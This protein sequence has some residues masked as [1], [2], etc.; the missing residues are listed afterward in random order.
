MPVVGLW[1]IW[2][3]RK[4]TTL[5]FEVVPVNLP[6]QEEDIVDRKELFLEEIDSFHAID[7]ASALK[8][9]SEL[10]LAECLFWFP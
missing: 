5:N 10:F 9:S 8:E 6:I 3:T 7:P 4:N 2:E 1:G